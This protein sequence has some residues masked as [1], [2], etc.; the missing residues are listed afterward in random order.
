MN[1][2]AH[3][4]FSLSLLGHARAA[5]YAL[6]IAAGAVAPDLLI[7]LFYGWE[8]LRDVPEQVIWEQHYYL[9]FWQGVFDTANSI[10]L[11]LVLGGL[12]YF[13]RRFALTAF[14]ASMLIHCLLD[15]PVHHDDGHRHFYPFSDF[16]FASPVSYW[17][18]AHHGRVVS[19]LEALLFTAGSVY[20]WR[21]ESKIRDHGHGLSA[22]Q[23]VIAITAVVYIGYLVYALVTWVL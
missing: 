3:V 20:L 19:I 6:A 11:I 21:A 13:F 14:F 22:L 4:V 17:D 18:A 16:R 12:A 2:P 5:R 8:K 10:P 9:P 7:I 15:L 1:T 23:S